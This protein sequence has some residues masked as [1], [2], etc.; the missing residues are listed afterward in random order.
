VVLSKAHEV[1]RPGYSR[2][3]SAVAKVTD[4]RENSGNSSQ[5]NGV[6]KMEEHYSS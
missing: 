6:S 1:V 4:R 3:T 5:V 2:L